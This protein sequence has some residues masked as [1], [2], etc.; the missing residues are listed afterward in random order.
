MHQDNG[1]AYYHVD[2]IGTVRAMTDAAGEVANSYVYGAFGNVLHESVSLEN[3]LLYAG[4]MRDTVLGWDFLRARYSSSQVGRFVTRDAFDGLTQDALSLHRYSYVHNDPLNNID[5]SGEVSLP[6]VLLGVS[7][8]SSV[9]SIIASF[10]GYTRT[11]NYLTAISI[12]SSLPGLFRAFALKAGTLGLKQGAQKGTVQIGTKT[13][14]FTL[15]GVTAL[16]LEAIAATSGRIIANGILKNQT[17]R[18]IAGA[19]IHNLRGVNPK[20]AIESIKYMANV[21]KTEI[22]PAAAT[23]ASKSRVVRIANDLLELGGLL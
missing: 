2:A 4:E 13:A 15:Q 5:P 18:D 12:A 21:L 20:T 19:V 16:E 3:S 17:S 7:I 23:S 10:A 9:G 22:A 11:A 1:T 6:S 14:E 8:I